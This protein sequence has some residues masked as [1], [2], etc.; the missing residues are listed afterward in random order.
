MFPV[1]HSDCSITMDKWMTNNRSEKNCFLFVFSLSISDT[2]VTWNAL[3]KGHSIYR[4]PPWQTV[5]ERNTGK[6]IKQDKKS[7]KIT[8]RILKKIYTIEEKVK[9]KTTRNPFYYISCPTEQHHFIHA[10]FSD[11]HYMQFPYS[12]ILSCKRKYH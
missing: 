6:Y 5:L 8:V 4:A 1:M 10:T 12:Q 9:L 7:I 11:K 2:T 3:T